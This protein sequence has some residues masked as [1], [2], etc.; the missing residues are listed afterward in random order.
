MVGG[1][2]TNWACESL[3]RSQSLG[4]GPHPGGT[5]NGVFG[6]SLYPFADG[7]GG[8]RWVGYENCLNQS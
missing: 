3:L 2:K 6:R 1:G 8:L 4:S 5:R 7:G